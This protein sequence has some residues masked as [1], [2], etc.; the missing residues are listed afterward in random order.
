MSGGLHER[1]GIDLP[2]DGRSGPPAST[3]S[4]TGGLTMQHSNRQ[5]TFWTITEIS[6]PLLL[7][8]PNPF[9]RSSNRTPAERWPAPKRRFSTLL[10]RHDVKSTP[11]SRTAGSHRWPSIRLNRRAQELLPRLQIMDPARSKAPFRQYQD[12]H[13]EGATIMENRVSGPL[14]FSRALYQGPI[15]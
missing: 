14:H 10:V 13:P 5:L 15:H 8:L 3:H 2:L 4:L 12:F 6:D 9:D 7:P 1:C 11:P